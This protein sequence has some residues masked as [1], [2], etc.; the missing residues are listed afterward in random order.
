MTKVGRTRL[1]NLAKKCSNGDYLT[2]SKYRKVI[3]EG[4]Q[5]FSMSSGSKT[6]SIGLK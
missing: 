3:R 4:D 5:L 6:K 1:L 2:V